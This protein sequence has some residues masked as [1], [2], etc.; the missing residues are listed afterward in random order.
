MKKL[1]FRKKTILL[2]ILSALV[3]YCG[4]PSMTA[5]AAGEMNI[6]TFT[7][8]GTDSL[9]RNTNIKYT[10]LSLSFS[11]GKAN[12]TA[13]VTAYA[14]NTTSVK[15]VMTLYKY[16]NGKWE[17]VQSWEDS[18]D[19]TTLTLSK[20]ETVSSGNYKL[21]GVFTANSETIE[22]TTEQTN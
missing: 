10:T 3:F 12:C 4:Q 19:G 5:L 1:F 7:E 18:A 21:V 6:D 14:A 8:G 17:F 15:I 11:S 13:S 16:T 2:L 9:L 22:K 20:S